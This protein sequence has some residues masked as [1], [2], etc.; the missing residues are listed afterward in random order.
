MSTFHRWKPEVGLHISY[1]SLIKTDLR[2]QHKTNQ[3]E[4]PRSQYW[5]IFKFIILC[6][7]CVYLYACFLSS[8]LFHNHFCL[9]VYSSL[10]T[11]IVIP[12]STCYVLLQYSLVHLFFAHDI[13]CFHGKTFRTAAHDYEYFLKNT[14]IKFD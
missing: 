14:L 1:P 9:F 6:I 12:S 11:E 8:Q 3:I 4:T 7:V 13:Y 10:F 2:E 5:R